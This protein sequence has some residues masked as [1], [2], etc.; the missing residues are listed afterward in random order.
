MK[1]FFFLSLLAITLVSCNYSDKKEEKVKT[2]P[3]MQKMAWIIGDWENINEETQSYESWIKVNDSTILAYST[4]LRKKDTVFAERMK[5]Y[6][7][8]DTLR[9]Y[10]ET[11]GEQPNPIVFTHNPGNVNYFVFTNPRNPFPSKLVYTQPSV[12]KIHA[13][14]EGNLDG[15]FQKMDFYLN[16]VETDKGSN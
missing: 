4:T 1:L 10:V 15:E 11:V 16:K 12:T 7:E 6:Y 13:W 3:E 14:V 2:Y 5:M 9:L 8:R